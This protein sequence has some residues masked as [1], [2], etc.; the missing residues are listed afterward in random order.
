[1]LVDS[2]TIATIPLYDNSAKAYKLGGVESYMR[3]L[4]K[5]AHERGAKVDAYQ[6]SDSEWTRDEGFFTLH[7]V[8]LKGG[9]FKSAN[10]KLF[11]YARKRASERGAI[12]ISGDHMNVK[13]RDPRAIVVE[14]GIA[15]DYP[16]GGSGPAFW[17]KSF[18]KLLRCVRNVV[19][20]QYVNN[21]VC[22]DYNHFN[23]LR[24]ISS[25][26]GGA[27]MKVIPNFCSGFISDAEFEEKLASR[28]NRKRR[29]VF[30]RRF[31]WYRGTELFANVAERLLR[32]F[33]DIEITFAGEGPQE[34]ILREKFGSS[35][36]VRI[37]SFHP[38]E[39]FDFHRGFDIAVVP[40]IFSEGTSLSLIEAMGAGCLP[41]CT[42]VGGMTNIVVDGFNGLMSYPDE[43]SFYECVRGALLADSGRF[44]AMARNARETAKMGLDY[45]SWSEKWISFIDRT[46]AARG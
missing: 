17:L 18:I 39:T 45:G 9:F 44:D 22:V 31:V 43:D 40:T 37:T 30:A 28:K 36:N 11:E 19:R 12:I 29:I 25:P 46:V 38:D 8:P 4:A 33:R 15:F 5:A 3:A 24:T 21:T 6:I 27:R 13:T 1:M 2:L 35:E 20:F 14:H 16:I 10:Q 23:W 42:H 34:G 26:Q 41:V 32:E 7:G